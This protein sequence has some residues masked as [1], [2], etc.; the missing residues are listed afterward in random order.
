MIGK[1]T[2]AIQS[3]LP[4]DLGEDVKKNIDAI[5]KRNFEKMNLVTREQFEIQEKI[6]KRTREKVE[7]LEKVVSELEKSHKK[8]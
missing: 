4:S 8:S 7:A 6:L 3:V 2:E 5:I 1:L